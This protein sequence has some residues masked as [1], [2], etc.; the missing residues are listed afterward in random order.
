MMMN[1]KGFGRKKSWPNLRY[2]A[3]IHLEGP[4]KTTK[5]LTQHSR[6]T[7]QRF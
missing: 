1:G 6:S 7:E 3:S 2:Y 5:N 4:R